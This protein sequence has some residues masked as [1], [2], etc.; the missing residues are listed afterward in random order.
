MEKHIW[1]IKHWF[2]IA[3]V[4]L[5]ILEIWIKYWFLSKYEKLKHW[6]PEALLFSNNF[7][8]FWL[9]HRNTFP[10]DIDLSQY[11]SIS[12]QRSCFLI[13]SLAVRFFINFRIFYNFP[14]LYLEKEYLPHN[15]V[16]STLR[17]TLIKKVRFYV[18][19]IHPNFTSH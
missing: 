8:F 6:V 10:K 9:N 3:F 7:R 1:K 4:K 17:I 15:F 2:S 5:A 18:K 12:L 13:N 19:N 16:W 14:M 11:L